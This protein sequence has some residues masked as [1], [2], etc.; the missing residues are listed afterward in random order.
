MRNKDQDYNTLPRSAP[1]FL[2]PGSPPSLHSMDSSLRS[3]PSS[4]LLLLSP[5]A[6]PWLQH[7]TLP[8]AAVLWD[9]NVPVGAPPWAAVGGDLLCCGPVHRLPGNICLT[10]L[11]LG[12]AEA[13]LLL[14]LDLLLS[15]SP[16]GS[17]SCF[18][19]FSLH[20]QAVLPSLNS[21]VPEA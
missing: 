9:K 6:F 4:S 16:W 14:K 21:A 20:H 12:A 19:L 17:Q 13:S 11:S 15:L 2:A 5:H 7:G 18:S 8:L 3:V 1:S 10:T